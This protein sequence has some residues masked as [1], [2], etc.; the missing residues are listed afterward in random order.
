MY[1]RVVREAEE[2]PH[3]LLPLQ[4]A[5]NGKNNPSIKF[6]KPFS[7][8]EVQEIKRDLI[9]YLEDPE[10]FTRLTLLY[11]LTLSDAMYVFR[12]T[13]TPESRARVLGKLL[14]LEMNGL[15]VRQEERRS[16]KQLSFLLGAKQSP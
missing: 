13:L 11:E 2:Q 6:L 9:D 7:Y 8:P 16:T 4:E 14:L 15:N 1:A 5:P 3:K 10:A 12:Q